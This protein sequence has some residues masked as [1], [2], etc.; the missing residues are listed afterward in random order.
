MARVIPA[1][2]HGI[3]TPGYW[4]DMP[5]TPEKIKNIAENQNL[6]I[7]QK[8]RC[9]LGQ[10]FRSGEIT[11]DGI[12]THDLISVL[13][14]PHPLSGI[15][16]VVLA[17]TVRYVVVGGKAI[18]GAWCHSSNPDGTEVYGHGETLPSEDPGT[19]IH[20]LYLPLPTTYDPESICRIRIFCQLQSAVGLGLNNLHILEKPLEE[21]E[22][23]NI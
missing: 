19:Y 3:S 10:A 14:K 16:P 20:T 2:P 12:G 8:T 15:I 7:A 1:S 17:I 22:F 6:I 5:I 23:Q 21:A 11:A 18:L 4:P 9:H 13:V